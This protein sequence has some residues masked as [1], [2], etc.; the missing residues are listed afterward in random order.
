[1]NLPIEYERQMQALLG[2]RYAAY[3]D[4]L[5]QKPYTG[6]R[7]NPLRLGQ[8]FLTQQ[9]FEELKTSLRLQEEIPWCRGAYYYNEDEIRP[10]KDPLYSTGIYYIQEPS[11][12]IPASVLPICA[13]DKV[14]DLCAA[15]GGKSTQIAAKL[16][17]TGLLVSNDLDESRCGAL[18]KNLE[19]TGATNFIVTNEDPARLKFSFLS[20][21]DKILVDA[22]CSGSGM[23]RKDKNAVK[24]YSKNILGDYGK[25][26][27]SLLNHAAQMLKPGG[28]MV[29]STC[30]FPLTENEEVIS[31]FLNEQPDF[32]LV[33]IDKKALGL[34]DAFGF[35]ECARIFPH[36]QKGE[37][38]F[39]AL[40]RKQGEEKECFP[41]QATSLVTDKENDRESDRK[42][43]SKSG[44]NSDNISDHENDNKNVNQNANKSVSKS[45]SSKAKAFKAKTNKFTRQ[46][47]SQV[48]FSHHFY[49]FYQD[50]L[51]TEPPEGLCYY[52]SY[53]YKEP[54]ELPDLSDIK[55]LR[56][57]FFLGQLTEF[58][59]EPSQ[60]L[61]M[62]LQKADAKMSIDLEPSSPE[63]ARYFR[64]DSFECELQNGWLLVCLQGFS[65]GWA[66]VFDGRIKNKYP[67]GWI[68]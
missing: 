34:G 11:A 54:E 3:L 23:F 47:L 40:L 35:E 57:G 60:A 22:P 42:N 39:V 61:S 58:S 15:P 51:H 16:N 59:F 8:D 10:G 28:M 17:N 55:V 12:M 45:A 46:P 32:E 36:E 67:K 24:A 37:G 53:I 5:E 43:D 20:Y 31:Q 30:T 27:L 9:S 68:R 19:L 49:S 50:W 14:L 13:H 6:I 66:K 33:P 21:F 65:V 48:K 2:S 38:H 56:N 52:G 41:E 1:M 44:K 7:M 64:G 4:C 25:T 63:L 62:S 26:Q 18:K 29:Y